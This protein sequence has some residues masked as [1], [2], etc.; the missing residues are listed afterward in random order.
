MHGQRRQ[1]LAVEA[2][3]ALVA[4]DQADDH[5][6]GGGLAGAVRAQQADHFAAADLQRNVLDHLAGLVALVSVLGAAARS[7]CGSGLR[8]LPGGA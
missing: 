3:L 7:W 5:V 4:G 2:D 8:L 1:V 6:E